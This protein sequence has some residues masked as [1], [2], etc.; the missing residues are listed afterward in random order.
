MIPEVLYRVKSLPM[1]RTLSRRDFLKLGGLTLGSLAFTPFLPEISQFDDIALVRVAIKSIS[2][3][4]EPSDK[5]L[6]VGQWF[7]DDIVHVYETVT[8][9]EPKYNP[10]WYHVWGGYMHRARLQQVKIHY[11][12][13]PDS[14]PESGMLAEVTVPYSQP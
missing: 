6:I 8:A 12:K 3:Y 11:N 13:P 1:A 9:E 5:S 4:K 10:I 2:V 14:I 7:R